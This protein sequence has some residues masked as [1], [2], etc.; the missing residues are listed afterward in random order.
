MTPG[1]PDVETIYSLICRTSSIIPEDILRHIRLASLSASGPAARVLAEIDTNCAMAAA[2]GVPICQDTGIPC[3]YVT[4]PIPDNKFM[5]LFEDAAR[6]AVRRAVKAGVLRPNAVEPLS[7][8]NRGDGTGV[9][10]PQFYYERTIDTPITVSLMLKGGGSE[11]SGVQYSLPD[12][13]IGAGRDVEGVRRCVL[14]AAFRAQGLGCAPGILGVCV[15]GDRSSG[16]FHA[17]KQLLRSLDEEPGDFADLE[18][19]LVKDINALSIGPMGLGGNPTVLG[20]KIVALD[21]HPASFFVTVSYG[22]WA[23]RR[24]TVVSGPG[25]IFTSI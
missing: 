9:G 1:Y 12:A 24:Q 5:A 22:C 8:R 23:T 2:D 21:R 13:S 17:K 20:V 14:D 16:Y 4:G 15:G 19:A 6:Q 11:N 10:I 25:G 7:G 18:S 3:F